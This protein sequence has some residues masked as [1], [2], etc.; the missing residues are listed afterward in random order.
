MIL[1]SAH[2]DLGDLAQGSPELIDSEIGARTGMRLIRRL[3]IG[4]MATVFVA[5]RDP[6]FTS[7][8][9]A[10]MTPQRLAVKIM[11]PST[12]R[13]LAKLGAD[14]ISTFKKEV[15]ALGKLSELSP[16]TP[17]VVAFY[18]CGLCEVEV[19]D[20]RYS[21]PWLA[22]EHVDGGTAGTSL[23]ER[24]EQTRGGV[25]PVRVLRL[26]RGIG[27][28]VRAIHQARII[29][30]DLKP[31][32]V[33][34]AGP[35]DDEVPKLSDCGIARVEGI[36]TGLAAATRAY[37][38][39][40][41]MVALPTANP[42]IGRWT[43]VHALAALFWFIIAGEQW[44]TD[45]RWF[46]GERRSLRNA[47]RIHPGFLMV[48]PALFQ[49]LD[50]VLMKGAAP[51]LPEKALQAP[52]IDSFVTMLRIHFPAALTGPRRYETVEQ[53]GAEL[54][55]I[56]ERIAA[57]WRAH[58]ARE[59]KPATA[60]R[61]TSL[62]ASSDASGAPTRVEEL[63]AKRPKPYDP[64]EPAVGL[65]AGCIAFQP[66][67]KVL[68]CSSTRVFFFLDG[69]PYL[70]SPP[71]GLSR[72]A[73]RAAIAATRWVQY[74]GDK[75]YALIAP[76]QLRTIRG[77][78]WSEL[79]LPRRAGSENGVG[80]AQDDVGEVH[81]ATGARGRLAIVT[82]ET[83]A[84]DGAPELWI[85][86]SGDTWEPPIAIPLNGEVHAIA[87]GPFGMLVVGS[88][89]GKRARA[90]FLS[91]DGGI[92]VYA[93]GLANVG[94]LRLALCGAE[95]EAWATSDAQI[96][97]FDRNAVEIEHEKIDDDPTALALDLVGVP[98]LVTART[99]WR[100]ELTG[101][102][103]AWRALHRRSSGPSLMAI[104]FTPDGAT[105]LDADGGIVRIA[106]SDL[107]SWQREVA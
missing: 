54:V 28:G 85:A 93:A 15:I 22:I 56:L 40:E 8:I 71:A 68:A 17:F 69:Q 30:R 25:D 43:D 36:A 52:G 18:G 98:W 65:R 42:L 61:P 44:C 3:G 104:G 67:G 77:G 32:N 88:R 83:D 72:E 19:R 9:L 82:G 24:V 107:R 6:S 90:A 27:E 7:S 20:G 48:E 103:A 55:P 35:I 51:G 38:G 63:P 4:G 64:S 47:A 80:V 99:V 37:A 23:T 16:P 45:S 84:S 92:N 62:V 97:R 91:P 10:P 53:F 60:Y 33:L 73:H 100:R 5:D 59:S 49:E 2:D 21:L 94:A 11:Q 70:T 86:A 66:D 79:P 41:Q 50:R 87:D 12:V 57:V 13:Q 58:A 76:R 105:V 14:P 29:H 106:P 101:S 95:R 46:L 74:L 81:A 26:V 102:R 1:R 89:G 78:Q 75:G 96:V 31:D 34:I 39:F